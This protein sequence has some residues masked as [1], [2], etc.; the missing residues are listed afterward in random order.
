MKGQ[1]G[2]PGADGVTGPKGRRGSVGISV[3]KTYLFGTLFKY[4]KP[5]RL[6]ELK[7]ILENLVHVE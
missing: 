3:L 4:L 1:E 7:E 2:E 5:C 6:M